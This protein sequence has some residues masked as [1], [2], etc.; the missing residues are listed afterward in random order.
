MIDVRE[1]DEWL[2]GHVEG[3]MHLP[4]SQLQ[5]GPVPDTL[6][7]DQPLYLYC[8]RGRRAKIA[9]GLLAAKYPLAIALE[10][11]YDELVGPHNQ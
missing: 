9:Q 3:A 10:K 4:L 7:K 6:P 8:A 5:K 11:G 2:E 1:R